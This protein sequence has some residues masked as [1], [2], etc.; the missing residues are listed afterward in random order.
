MTRILIVEDD[1]ATSGLLKTVFEME[2]FKVS[3]CP[4][5]HRVLDVVREDDPDLILMDYHLADM[6]S[7]PILQEIKADEK[8]KKIAI[9]MTSGLDRSELCKESGANS[10]LLKPFRPSELLAEVRTVL[11]DPSP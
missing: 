3:T 5:A 6:E 4:D 2:G 1:R 9:V 8:L 10:F 7:L 11:G